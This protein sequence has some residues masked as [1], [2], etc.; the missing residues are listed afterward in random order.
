MFYGHNFTDQ[1]TDQKIFQPKIGER[2]IT[3]PILINIFF[4]SQLLRK[5]FWMW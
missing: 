1:G 5:D 4:I 3:M 2:A